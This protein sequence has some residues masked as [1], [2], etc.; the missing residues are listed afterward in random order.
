MLQNVL[1]VT[2]FSILSAALGFVSQ[3]V[4]ASTFGASAEMDLYFKILSLPAIVT[5]ISPIIFSSVFIPAFASFSKNQSELT[6]FINSIWIFIL[7]FGF[8]FF[9][10]GVLI[11]FITIDLFIPENAIYLREEGI[12]VSLMVWVGSAFMIMS[13]YLSAILNYN[14]QFIKVAW[15]SLLPASFMIT[16]VLSFSTVLGVRSISAGFCIAALV[17]FVFFIKA[18]KISFQ[19]VEFKVSNIPYKKQLLTQSCLAI[20]SL[21]PFTMLAPIAYFW[22]SKLEVGSIS[23]LGYAQSFAGFLSVAASMGITVVSF[24]EWADKFARGKEQSSLYK[25][26]QSLRY[27]LLIAMF[28]AGAFIA[29]RIPILTLFYQ[30]G[31]FSVDSVNNLASV[32]PWYLTAAVFVGGLNVMRNLF[33]SRGQ[34]KDLAWLGLLT[35]IIFF[36]LAGGLKDEFSFV[37]IGMAYAVTMIFLFSFNI[38]LS[39]NTEEKFLTSSFLFFILKSASSVIAASII[40]AS[41]VSLVSSSLSLLVGIPVCLVLFLVCYFALSKYLFKLKEINEIS[42]LLMGKIKP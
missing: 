38:F 6:K 10:V 32:V 37:G 21:L 39:R 33:Y 25:V 3:I 16:M 11:S 15:T 14:R 42:L 9:A 28:A 8:L 29:L 12:Q 26:E 27:V 40:A 5:G 24:P 20:L 23:Y 13:S 19:Y 30:R 36:V 4:F 34:Y 22:A 2:I 7:A 31:S 18:A 1:L 35:P 41:M 17:Q